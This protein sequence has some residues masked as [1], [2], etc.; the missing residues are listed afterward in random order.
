MDK[1]AV[2]GEIGRKVK[3]LSDAASHQSGSREISAASGGESHNT[4]VMAAS[5]SG[6]ICPTCFFVQGV[7]KLFRA[8]PS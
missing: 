8:F 2:D 3:I 5:A 7:Q 6:N 1:T 4:A